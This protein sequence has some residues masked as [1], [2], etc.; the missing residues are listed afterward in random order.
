MIHDLKRPVMMNET[1][2]SGFDCDFVEKPPK[3]IQSECPVCLLIIREPYQA[4]CCGYS[5]C[6]RCIDRIKARNN[7][8]PCCKAK[9]FESFEDKR[10]KRSLYEL[11][12][13]CSNKSQ[14]CQ[15]VGEL[16]QLDDHINANPSRQKLS[17]GCKYTLVPC[18]YCDLE[19]SRSTIQT[20][21]NDSCPKRPF[22]CVY[23]N[24]Y[25][26]DYESV[27]SKHWQT[28]GYYPVPCPN[29]CGVN[30]PRKNRTDLERHIAKECYL[31]KID[32][33]FKHTG[34][35]VKLPRRD[36]QAHLDKSH[37]PLKEEEN[38]SLLN[39]SDDNRLHKSTKLPYYEYKQSLWSQRTKSPRGNVR[40][41]ADE[42]EQ[43]NVI[44]GLFLWSFLLLVVSAVSFHYETA[45]VHNRL[46]MLTEEVLEL[47]NH[48]SVCPV[49]ITFS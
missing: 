9:R 19:Q 17:E 38:L 14:G 23:C 2:Q 30:I 16:R 47:R 12:V 44:K 42:K 37:P 48:A 21:Q 8:C 26:S 41:T 40:L 31:A 24:R 43:I 5:Y 46:A 22:K 33:Y 10:L 25:T 1:E 32:C 49:N 45:K 27:S 6:K 28:C 18:P 3:A 20:H 34:C 7:A 4:T 36:M 39:P 13:S 15:W 29:K 11:K 35:K